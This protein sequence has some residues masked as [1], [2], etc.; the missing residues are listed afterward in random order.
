MSTA[1]K[2][3]VIALEIYS[4]WMIESGLAYGRYEVIHFTGPRSGEVIFRTDQKAK[5]MIWL[6]LNG[7]RILFNTRETWVSDRRQV[8]G[9]I[10]Q[11]PRHQSAP[12]ATGSFATECIS[13]IKFRLCRSNGRNHD[14]R[15]KR[16]AERA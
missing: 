14:R 1:R 9:F 16:G 13:K 2:R 12:N 10:A 7:L 4:R 3:Q 5:L 15:G 11:S 6:D 8:S